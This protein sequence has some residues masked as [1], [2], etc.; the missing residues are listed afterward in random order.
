MRW[1]ITDYLGSGI[2]RPALDHLGFHVESVAALQKDLA[3]MVERDPELAP[4]RA[5]NADEGGLRQKLFAACP[6]GMLHLADPD[7]VLID[8]ADWKI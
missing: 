7:G 3:A 8:V 5:R 2:E 4:R 6:H 1:D